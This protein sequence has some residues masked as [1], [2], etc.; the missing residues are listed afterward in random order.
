LDVFRWKRRGGRLTGG[1][2][3]CFTIRENG[4]ERIQPQKEKRERCVEVETEK[5]PSIRLRRGPSKYQQP[6]KIVGS[7]GQAMISIER[8]LGKGPYNT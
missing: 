2:G 5:N 4:K 3:N 7:E 1:V 8:K 6:G